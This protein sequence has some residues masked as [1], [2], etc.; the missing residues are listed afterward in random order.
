M[1]STKAK[2]E[3]L[4]RLVAEV[5]CSWSN[6]LRQLSNACKWRGSRAAALL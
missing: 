6:V 4:D 3:I 5:G 2:R 1:A